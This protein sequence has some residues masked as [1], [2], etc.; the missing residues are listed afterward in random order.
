MNNRSTNQDEKDWRASECT[1]NCIFNATLLLSLMSLHSSSIHI[2]FKCQEDALR[3]LWFLV[4]C[5]NQD[6]LPLGSLSKLFFTLASERFINSGGTHSDRFLREL[7]GTTMVL[8]ILVRANTNRS[9]T[10]LLQT[11]Y[12]QTR[13]LFR[14]SKKSCIFSEYMLHL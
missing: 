14:S 2:H 12:R 1:I 6:N 13:S 7:G 8:T 5:R 10:H 3:H 4:A 11:T 9:R